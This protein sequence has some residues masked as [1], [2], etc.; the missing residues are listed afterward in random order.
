MA[1]PLF[2]L[3]LLFH[4]P[5]SSLDKSI[6]VFLFIVKMTDT[7][8]LLLYGNRLNTPSFIFYREINVLGL[9]VFQG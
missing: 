9:F 2:S 7:C 4:L 1:D 3:S 5:M 6:F 8:R